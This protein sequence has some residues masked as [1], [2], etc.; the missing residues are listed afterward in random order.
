MSR[1]IFNVAA[2]CDKAGRSQNQDNFWVCPDLNNLKGKQEKCFGNDE[3]LELS[4]KGALLVVADGMGGMNAGE[5]ASELIIE[6]VQKHFSAIPDNILSDDAAIFDFIRTSI[7]DADLSIKD[8]AKHHRDAEGLGSTIVLLWLLGS[9]AYCAWCGDSRIYRYNPNNSIVRLSHDHSYVQGLVDEGKIRP[10]DAFDHPDGNIITRSLG[11]NGEKVNPEMKVYDICERDVFLLCSDGLCGLLQDNEIENIVAN[12]CSSTKDALDAL[13]KAGTEARWADNSTIELLAVLSGGKHPKGIA[14]GYPEKKN[15]PAM[16]VPTTPVGGKTFDELPKPS[17][18]SAKKLVAWITVALLLLLL[19]GAGV[20]YFMT[21]ESNDGNNTEYIVEGEN[22][23]FN[24][25]SQGYQQ[26]SVASEQTNNEKVP[27][28]ANGNSAKETAGVSTPG[29]AASGAETKDNN[30][31]AKTENQVDSNYLKHIADVRKD[32]PG[33]LGTIDNAR[34]RGSI[35]ANEKSKLQNFVANVNDLA[36]QKKPSYQSLDN[37]TKEEIKLW[38][39]KIDDIN[40]V[41]ELPVK[42]PS[43]VDKSLVKKVTVVN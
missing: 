7:V 9:K 6:V 8:F 43:A 16:V 42:K 17:T 1:I 26:Q 5:K 31:A 13:W 4:D 23:S 19:S 36:D 2:K 32:F 30:P 15:L 24:F 18:G 12:N 39:S 29:K 40:E 14:V 21:R 10:E 35:T 37:T 25:N 3:D 27:E 20:Y 38:K 28:T 33:I 11:D 34:T 41:L 22:Q